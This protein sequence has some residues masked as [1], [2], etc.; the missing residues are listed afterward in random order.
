MSRVRRCGQKTRKEIHEV[1]RKERDVV[2]KS[3][4]YHKQTQRTR[5]KRGIK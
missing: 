3:R 2:K 5:E 4:N 1:E